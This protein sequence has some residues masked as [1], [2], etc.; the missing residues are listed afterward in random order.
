MVS[1]TYDPR[2]DILF[3]RFRL[4]K[5]QADIEEVDD[6]II[7]YVD[8]ERKII[9]LEIWDAVSRGFL[10]QLLFALGEAL[11]LIS[12]ERENKNKNI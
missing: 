2:S 12:K 5:R 6:G 7:L 1:I 3:I 9:G 10:S 11:L 4:N 8:E